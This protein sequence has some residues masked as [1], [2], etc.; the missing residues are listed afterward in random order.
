[1]NLPPGPSNAKTQAGYARSP[2][3]TNSPST[4][5]TATGFLYRYQ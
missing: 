5:R 2:A 1:M 3:E 4:D